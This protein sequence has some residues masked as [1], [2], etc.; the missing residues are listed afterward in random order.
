[1]I[2]SPNWGSVTCQRMTENIILLGMLSNQQAGPPSENKLPKETI[3]NRHLPIKRE[4]DIANMLAFLSATVHDSTRVMAVCIEEYPQK[5]SMV[6]KIASN[7]GDLKEVKEA[8]E[9]IAYIL[10]HVSTKSK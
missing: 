6:I 1:M 5:N 3:S 9:R 2:A 7:T 4:R 8:F 10:E